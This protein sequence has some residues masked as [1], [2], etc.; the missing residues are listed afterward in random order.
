MCSLSTHTGRFDFVCYYPD[1]LECAICKVGMCIDH[2]LSCGE[3]DLILCFDCEPVHRM[4]DDLVVELK[5]G[6][7]QAGGEA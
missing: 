2:A 5:N 4:V 6:N 7:L 3:C 1:V